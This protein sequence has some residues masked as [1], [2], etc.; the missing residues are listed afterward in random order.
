MLWCLILTTL[1]KPT[2]DT[3]TMLGTKPDGEP[4]VAGI[5]NPDNSSDKEYIAY[6]NLSGEALVTSGSY[7]RYYVVDGKK[8]HHIIDSQTLMPAENFQSVSVL[9]KSSAM[10]DALSTALFCMTQDEGMALVEV[11]DGVEAMWVGL[12]GVE[13]MSSGFSDYTTTIS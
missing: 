6:L 5:E 2:T 10:A 13:L 12:D 11:L 9:C 8:Y 1:K 3:V 4:W 7:Q